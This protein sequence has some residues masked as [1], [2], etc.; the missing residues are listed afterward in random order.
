MIPAH[1]R[2]TFI[3]TVMAAG[4]LGSV[5]GTASVSHASASGFRY[6]NFWVVDADAWALPQATP[7]ERQLSDF[8]VD[9]WHFGIWG[10]D[11]GAPPRA[12]TSFTSLCPSLAAKPATAGKAR[13]AVVLD[14]GSAA[15][16]PRGESPRAI[17][18]VC[19]TVP[20]GSSSR[21]ALERAATTVRIELNT[22]CAIDDYPR[23]ECAP[24]VGDSGTAT[25]TRTDTSASVT[26][27][28]TTDDTNE[29]GTQGTQQAAWQ[30]AAP[31]LMA[32]VGSLLLV[33]GVVVGL[34]RRP[35]RRNSR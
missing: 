11:G 12:V 10:D 1:I 33:G 8:D 3:A 2:A 27:S 16:A 20:E 24:R 15:D 22:I 30:R 26:S 17:R 14:P 4:L 18:T 25:T 19:L 32:L 29:T 31:I 6:W 28:M 35:R 9:G 23:S 7:Q 21:E 5:L 13:I 34:R